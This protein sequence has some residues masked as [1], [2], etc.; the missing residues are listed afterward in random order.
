MDCP[1]LMK[2]LSVGILGSGEATPIIGN[3]D[4]GGIHIC[5][6][7]M[8]NHTTL[9]VTQSFKLSLNTLIIPNRL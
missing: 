9:R 5:G 1:G 6:G 4:L 7:R 3:Q 2:L 8:G